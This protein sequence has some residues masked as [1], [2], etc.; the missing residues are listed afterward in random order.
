[1]CGED[2]IEHLKFPESSVEPVSGDTLNSF[3]VVKKLLRGST[4][5]LDRVLSSDEFNRLF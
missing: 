2:S 5:E 1:M 3:K 4:N